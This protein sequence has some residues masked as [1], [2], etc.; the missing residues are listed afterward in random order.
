VLLIRREREKA[1]EA[2]DLSNRCAAHAQHASRALTAFTRLVKKGVLHLI[3][4]AAM[5]ATANAEPR[6]CR[7]KPEPNWILRRQEIG[8]VQGVPTFRL[9][10]GKREVDIYRDGKAFE[11]DNRVR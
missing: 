7:H 3:L 6:K 11:K 9:I 1:R 5:V 4:A 2:R 8:A 10:I